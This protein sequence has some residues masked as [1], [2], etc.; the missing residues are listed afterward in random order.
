MSYSINTY[1]IQKIFR[2]F[3]LSGNCK[4]TKDE[5]K[6][7]LYNFRSEAQIDSIVDKLFLLLDGDN[8]GYIEFE[9]FLRACIDKNNILTRE[10]MWYA[11]KFLDK[12]NKNSIDVQTLMKAFDAK[13]NKMLE[14]VFN[15][16]LN[17]GD[18]DNNGEITFD[19]FEEIMKNSMKT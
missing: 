7:G 12:Q 13:P 11:F 5:L 2:Y 3:N 15:K 4:L 1:I 6:K 17:D 9:E 16:T 18:L 19:E 8:N 14:V 10:N